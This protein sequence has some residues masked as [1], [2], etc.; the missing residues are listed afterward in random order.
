MKK[1]RRYKARKKCKRISR[2]RQRQTLRANK[3][4]KD[5]HH[6]FYTRNKWSHGPS[7]R[8]RLYPYCIVLIDKYT[9]HKYIHE[10]LT[11]IPTP[12]CSSIREVL[13]QLEQLR[14]YGAISLNDPIEKRLQV[15]IALFECVEQPTANALKKQLK[16][17]HDIKKPSD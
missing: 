8:L 3:N 17:V 9:L 4:A 12:R 13:Y 14:E 1:K 2:Q 10:H 11:Y 16:L 5:K 6:I 15:L 7:C